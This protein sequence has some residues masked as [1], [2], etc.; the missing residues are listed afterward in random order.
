LRNLLAG[1]FRDETVEFV[2]PSTWLLAEQLRPQY[3]AYVYQTPIDTYDERGKRLYDLVNELWQEE[4]TRLFGSTFRVVPFAD[5]T[6][7]QRTLIS[8]LIS[9]RTTR[10]GDPRTTSRGTGWVKE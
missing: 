1:G 6:S 4:A 5:P 3:A 8:R 9:V 2:L 7:I 10:A